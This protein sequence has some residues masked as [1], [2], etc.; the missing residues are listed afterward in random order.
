MTTKSSEGR[1][2]KDGDGF[3]LYGIKLFAKDGIPK[4]ELWVMDGL[5]VKQKIKLKLTTPPT[6]KY[7]NK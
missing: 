6:T 3:E 5:V 4:D 7:E 2:I 1:G